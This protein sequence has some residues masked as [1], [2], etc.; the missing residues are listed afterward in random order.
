M[1]TIV[2]N[3]DVDTAAAAVPSPYGPLTRVSDVEQYPEGNSN[4]Q[5]EF[6]SNVGATVLFMSYDQL[7]NTD[8]RNRLLHQAHPDDWAVR[9][10]KTAINA[11]NTKVNAMSAPY[12]YAD[13]KDLVSDLRQNFPVL[14]GGFN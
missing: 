14:R 5:I 9:E 10:L 6:T 1:A 12:D 11:L 7:M 13:Y 4:Q 8:V 2:D 3:S